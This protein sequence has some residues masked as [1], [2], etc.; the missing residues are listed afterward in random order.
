MGK[1]AS[2]KI[3][4]NNLIVNKT[5]VKNQN[6]EKLL[7]LSDDELEKLFEEGKITQSEYEYILKKK[8]SKKKSGQNKFEERIRCD[9]SII[10]KIVKLGQKFRREE[11]KMQE[12]ARIQRLLSR[13][14]E[15]EPDIQ[16][17]ARDREKED[18]IRQR[19]NGRSKDSERGRER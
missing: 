3:G 1:K 13:T 2:K 4:R 7:A 5:K 11:L 6:E 12:E 16:I 17:G 18:R 14:G 19:N 15:E 8:K 9:K 10:D